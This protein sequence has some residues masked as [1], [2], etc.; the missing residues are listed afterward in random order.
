VTPRTF[1]VLEFSTVRDRLASRCASVFGRERAVALLPSTVPDDVERALRETTEARA[2]AE[3]AG[4]LPLGGA[5]D[6]REPVRRASIG[7]VLEAREL[8]G[9]RD[10]AAV[11]RTVKG[12]VAARRKDVP[13]LAE[14]AEALDVFPSLEAAIGAAIGPEGDI[15][16]GASPELARLRRERR[17][18]EGRLHARLEEL[19]R[20]PAVARMLR[21]PLITL[22]GERYTVPVRAEFRNQF[23]GVAH[24]QSSSGVTVFM[25][26]LAVVPLANQVREL[27]LSERDE[28]ARILAALS[29]AVGAAADALVATLEVLGTLDLAA[30]K[31]RLSIEMGGA[32]P[33]LNAA[34]RLELRRARHPLLPAGAV[35]IDV[36]LGGRFR[37]LIITG[38]N[39]G[40][41]TVTLKTIG[42]LTLMA[43]AGLHIPAA[44]ESD[45]VVFPQI[46]A[47]IGDEQSI[48][49]SLS[50]FS[51]HLGAIVEILRALAAAPPGEARALVLL[52]EV[53]AGTDPAEGVALARALIEALH[54][55]GAYVAVTTHYNELKSM[56]YTHPGMENASV[57]FDDTTLRPTYR[58][59]TGTPGRS[60]AFAIA[61]RLGLDPQ[62]VAQATH[63]LSRRDADLTQVLQSVEAD[64]RALLEERELVARERAALER[65]RAR[66]EEDA[67]RADA[68]RRQFFERAQQDVAAVI[69]RGRQELDEILDELRRQPSQ[70][71][72]SRARRSLQELAQASATYAAQA[73]EAPAGSPPEDLRPGETVF[74]VSLKQRGTVQAAPDNRGEVELQVG[75]VKL[76]V[77]TDDLRRLPEGEPGPRQVTSAGD[78]GFEKALAI[79]PALDLRGRRVEDAVQ[80]LDK[81]LDDAT[82]AGLTQVTVIHGKGT[83]ALRQ[84]VRDHLSSHPEVAAF[85]LGGEAEGGS[86]ATIVELARR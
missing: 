63:A 8:L 6:I 37:T 86:G 25:E 41:K 33:R 10:T 82:L 3:E 45:V 42:L 64:R 27:A 44:P 66:A 85:R 76:R 84:A 68:E 38:P 28:I 16:D 19:L 72:A 81:Y 51:S 20:A 4:G 55:R 70:Q 36:Q 75:A 58:L 30:A 67:R 21:E 7:G 1:R 46:Y 24:D 35:P 73:E 15:L 31:A 29:G 69:R 47:D 9:V 74:V 43:Q 17:I 22:R 59:L 71:A 52:D 40:G 11:A 56:P 48:A 32:A 23:P 83:G 49:Q 18:G 34:G 13:V 53:G 12:F 77:P 26:P 61:E 60:N 5:S 62:I 50:T 39:T 80:E 79:S 14:M 78:A 54:D 65:L 2:L 57:E